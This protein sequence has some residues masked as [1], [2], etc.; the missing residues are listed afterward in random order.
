[1][2][3]N[4]LCPLKVRFSAH[5]SHWLRSGFF[6]IPSFGSHEHR[7]CNP[8]KVLNLNSSVLKMEVVLAYKSTW[9]DNPEDRNLKNHRRGNLKMYI[10]TEMLSVAC[11]QDI[12]WVITN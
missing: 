8:D 6:V 3:K 5:I 2:T 1:V 4:L 7:P 12:T 11:F 10:S 9:C